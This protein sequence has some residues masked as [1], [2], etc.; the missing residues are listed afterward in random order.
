MTLTNREQDGARIKD[1][2]RLGV[3]G[4]RRNVRDAPRKK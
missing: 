3:V 2:I 4:P 1:N